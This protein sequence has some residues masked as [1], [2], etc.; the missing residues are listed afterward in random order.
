[1]FF[2]A[3]ASDYDGTLALHGHVDQ[4][5]RDALDEVKECGRKLLLVTGRE[6]ADLKR[7]FDQLEIFDL[8][9][10]ESEAECRLSMPQRT[11][12]GR[13]YCR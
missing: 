7:G 10:A 3:L 9:V 4:P 1:M 2:V 8:V 6:L 11:Q 12:N 13:C 5:T